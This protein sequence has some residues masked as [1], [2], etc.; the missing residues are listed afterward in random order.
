MLGNNPTTSNAACCGV[1]IS[2]QKTNFAP[3]PAWHPHLKTH[4]KPQTPVATVDKSPELLINLF[5]PPHDLSHSLTASTAKRQQIKS[6]RGFFSQT[7]TQPL[8]C[9]KAWSQLLPQQYLASV[10]SMAQAGLAKQADGEFCSAA[11]SDA[12]NQHSSCQQAMLALLQT[13]ACDRG[14]PGTKAAAGTSI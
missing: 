1:H 10:S 5:S 7:P 13:Q 12:A 8:L 3:Q 6:E 2:I 14:Q 9:L 11:A 4:S